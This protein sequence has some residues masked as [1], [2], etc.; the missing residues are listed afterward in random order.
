[1]SNISLDEDTGIKNIERIL[2]F[3]KLLDFHKR[4]WILNY[5][6]KPWHIPQCL[7]CSRLEV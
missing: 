5:E 3:V 2:L 7:A 1:M 4:F 6:L